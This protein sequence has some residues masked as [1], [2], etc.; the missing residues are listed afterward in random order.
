MGG[1]CKFNDAWPKKYSWLKAVADD[2]SSAFCKLCNT[3]FKVDSKGESSVTRHADGEKH[4]SYASNVT[5]PLTTFFQGKDYLVYT[6]KI[7]Y[8][9][10]HI[11]S[12]AG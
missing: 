10:V 6:S 1:K 9:L 5:K 11:Y 7:Y 3:S 8:N 4:K 12:C 2:H